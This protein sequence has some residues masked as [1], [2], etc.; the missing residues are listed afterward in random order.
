MRVKRASRVGITAAA[1]FSWLKLQKLK[2]GGNAKWQ[3]R[4]NEQRARKQ[5]ARYC[6]RRIRG[7]A[8][9]IIVSGGGVKRPEVVVG[10]AAAR[11]AFPIIR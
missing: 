4:D 6:C 7:R 9:L 5:N 8:A 1:A 3:L 11:R 2:V 10:A